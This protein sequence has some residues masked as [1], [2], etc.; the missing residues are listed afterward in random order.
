MNNSLSSQFP[1][2]HPWAS[3]TVDIFHVL[4]HL[5]RTPL[6]NVN[7]IFN[8]GLF[9]FLILTDKY[10]RPFS[11]RTGTWQRADLKNIC[12]KS[13]YHQNYQNLQKYLLLLQEEGISSSLGWVKS[14]T[15]WIRWLKVSQRG[16]CP[17]SNPKARQRCYSNKRWVQLQNQNSSSSFPTPWKH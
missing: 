7:T 6:H 11:H 17:S 12:S 9:P 4:H 16:P 2:S 1:F 8:L 5:L 3:G 10:E 13:N 14:E 15:G